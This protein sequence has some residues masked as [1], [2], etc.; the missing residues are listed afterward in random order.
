MPNKK[1]FLTIIIS[2]I[3]AF[4]LKA[5]V[6]TEFWFVVPAAIQAHGDAPIAFRVTALDKPATV[7]LSMP[8]NTGFT[9]KTLELKAYEQGK[10]EYT[11]E[12]DV[13]AIENQP[14][15]NINKKG[16]LI[17]SDNDVTVYY[18]VANSKN[19]DKF[20]LKGNNALG[21]SF[22]ASSQTD[23]ANK[24][25]YY[26]PLPYEKIDI[27]ATEDG[28][29]IE[30]TPTADIIGHN[31]NI[32]Y[33]ISLN[34]GETYCIQVPTDSIKA[35]YTLSGTY[36]K[37]NKNIAVTISD[38]SVTDEY[39]GSW[40][41]IG[42]QT[43]P[44]SVAGTEY[45]AM[46]SG[47]P[48]ENEDAIL[49]IQKVYILATEDNTT[50]TIDKQDSSTGSFDLQ[51]GESLSVDIPEN[52]S[53][54]I[55]ST[56]LHIKST[57]PV[58]AY[59][60]SGLVGSSNELG[61]AIL[62]PIKCTG[63]SSVTFT[64]VLYSRFFI[65]V[66]TQYKNI[67]HFSFN[68]SGLDLSNANWLK[69]PNTGNDKDDDTWYFI[70]KRID[71]LAVGTPYTISNSHGLFHLSVFDENSGS[72]SFGYFSAF[73]SLKIDGPVEECQG[74]VITL[75]ANESLSTYNWFSKKTKDQILS[76]DP[77][78]E[79][80]ESGLYWVV[81]TR[82]INSDEGCELTDSIEVEFNIPE[83]D[84]GDDVE[85]CYNDSYVVTPTIDEGTFYWY[86]ESTD[87][88]Y[89]YTS[90]TDGTEEIWLQITDKYGCSAKD[91][92]KITT[93]PKV[94]IDLNI[95]ITSQN[96]ICAG[97]KIYNSTTLDQYEWRYGD[98]NS[99][100]ISSDPY[101]YADQSGW[102]YLSAS[103]D[104]CSSIDSI[105]VSLTPIPSYDITDELLC[106]DE[107]Y[108]SPL[109][110]N[111]SY[112]YSWKSVISGINSNASQISINQSDSIYVVVTDNTT[113]CISKD[114][115]LISFREETTTL[116]KTVSTC[117][118]NDV[119]LKA[120]DKIISNY[121]WTFNNLVLTETGQTLT[122]SKILKS[123][124]GDYTVTGLD[125]NGC[126][127][128]QVFTLKV[129]L[130]D[131]ID[132]GNDQ[133]ICA[134]ESTTLNIGSASASAFKWYDQNPITNT[135]LTP[136]ATSVNYTVNTQG[137]YYVL[138]THSNGCN[139]IDSINITVNSLPVINLP[140]NIEEC[141]GETETYDAGSGFTDYLW[142]D[143]ST[144]QTY[145][146]AAPQ[147][148][149]VTITDQNGCSNSDNSTYTWKEVNILL[150]DTTTS[151]P[152]MPYIIETNGNISNV[153]WFF[154]D[155]NSTINLNNNSNTYLINSVSLSDAGIYIIKADQAECNQITDTINLYVVDVG[156][157]NLGPDKT[158]CNGDAIQL[159]ANDGFDSYQWTLTNGVNAG[160]KS[161]N[162]SILAGQYTDATLANEEWEVF[163]VHS[164]GCSLTDDIVVHK[165]DPPVITL[166]DHIE[167]CPSAI[168]NLNDLIDFNNTSSNSNNP[169]FADEINYFW[170]NS[171]TS[172]SDPE[173]IQINESGTYNLTI[174]NTNTD[175]YNPGN[176][177][178]CYTKTEVE[179]DY[180]DEFVVP[181]L[182]DQYICQGDVT[183]LIAPDE[184]KNY[185]ELQNYQWVRLDNEKNI[186]ESNTL[187]SD[188]LNINTPSYY[189][190]NVTYTDKSCLASDTMILSEK[191]NPDLSI[192]GDNIICQGLSTTFYANSSSYLNYLWSTG[193][194][195]DT[196]T[197]SA[198]G[199]YQL[200]V[201]GTNNCTSTESIDL[202][203]NDTPIIN[204]HNNSVSICEG[205][206]DDITVESVKYP[207]NS[208]AVNPNYL[209]SN[210]S[211]NS[212]IS[213]TEPGNYSVKVTDQ[214]G[215]SSEAEAEVIKYPHTQIDLSSIATTGCSNEGVL[216]ECPFTVGTDINSFQWNKSGSTSGNPAADT[217]WTVYESGTYVLTII[218]NNLC[219]ESDSVTITIY[220]SPVID[221]GSDKNLCVGTTLSIPS[222]ENYN[223]YIWSNGSTESSI[224]IEEAS[225]PVNY[226]VTVYNENG[227]F[228]TDDINI[229]PVALPVVTLNEPATTCPG[230][231]VELT[232]QIANKPASYSIWWSNNSNSESITVGEGKYI[233]SVT[234]N[235]NGCSGSDTTTVR[236]FDAP[237]VSL[238]ADTLICPLVEIIPISPLEGDIYKNYLWH[239][240]LTSYE[241]N[242]DVGYI[243]TVYVTDNN[244]C[245]TFD[246]QKIQY[247]Q[248]EDTTYSFSIC[249][250][251]TT[252]SLLDLDPDSENH[253]GEYLW[254][255]DNSTYEYKTFIEADTCIVNIG[256]TLDNNQTTCY[257][258]QDT[259]VMSYYPLPQIE[260]LDTTIYCQV[261]LKM[262][263]ENS[264]YQYSLDS[265]NW[266][267]ENTFT[268]LTEGDY[269]VYIID[270]N[271]CVNSQ[272][273]SISEDV[274]IDIPGFFT[275]NNDGYNDTWEISGIE[276]LPNSVIRIYDRY[277]KLLILY[278]ASDPGWDGTYQ[279][280]QM[281]STDYW[282]VVELLPIKKLL[283]GH[284]TLK[285]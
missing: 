122:L 267:Y 153:S 172:T 155:G 110:S 162:Q 174:S 157:I 4:S 253:T 197:V 24:E 100:I 40:D 99:A 284:F 191:E 109:N 225:N 226:S 240:N 91:T 72:A 69:V 268:E 265:L 168:I 66:L 75:K 92:I 244:N 257:Y 187:N 200:T 250:K 43:I 120:D 285:R 124:E 152:S 182:T 68:G 9:T 56:A 32:S 71:G 38:D 194:T 217:N 48:Q 111:T 195:S 60:L 18:E 259:V 229:T 10:F 141:Q 137:K 98:K 62:P 86:D 121:S 201:E 33:S 144:N 17:T 127:I 231:E 192:L 125:N 2:I 126:S 179:V 241:I 205:S 256:I 183:N 275:P 181:G 150:K 163:A 276:K 34:R 261:T 243:N 27:V 198:A 44:I 132:L 52:K 90:T 131:P 88:T 208:D 260:T 161:T 26:D 199:S 176:S 164:S 39:G 224:T 147:N 6:D 29:S 134:G 154:S 78:L 279:N 46:F 70:N 213:V 128:K 112:S 37:S 185:N 73:N 165:V 235:E 272:T 11:S 51:K 16:I 101:I 96:S 79:V 25:Y 214:N 23:Y 54:T 35:S 207:D 246:Q 145:T 55:K 135:G 15:D 105:E 228:A 273:F 171:S 31:K 278:S 266:Q 118:F 84:L 203:V 262:D 186:A 249:E 170:N 22:F 14:A 80:T 102:Y 117:A 148:I 81:A 206:S 83:F 130:G 216:L 140:D 220:E 238:G 283:K 74:E 230:I 223:S 12:N 251:D 209:W 258:K 5:Q 247:M 210:W 218:D 1:I 167:P 227:C 222:P 173:T 215:C 263:M 107:T 36:I 76:T 219:E 106:H 53:S 20:T 104:G 67:K 61:S 149:S 13:N 175:P 196:I 242:G 47:A 239:N 77:L 234:D 136:I 281:P 63:S 119:S 270:N 49:P 64:R 138:T 65:Q 269:T 113:G 82:M 193:S 97:S 264:P 3:S 212:Y 211:T 7:T 146:A 87:Q 202:T 190:L 142:Q 45:I 180:K 57:A 85:V 252:I 233:V 95:D 123:Q 19:P 89:T 158:I 59:Q 139:S 237:K 114:S 274:E 159:N 166:T 103:L 115:A 160:V 30:I 271:G 204:L 8:A 248:I 50:V 178:H 232:P 42:D 21:T 94:P 280:K 221:L 255:N 236:W 93:L 254:L 108:Y 177:F 245:T 116:P 58:Y 143:G 188:W 277:G 189:A 282:Y 151:C 133:S 169:F 129:I 156:S 41:L 184:V 28:T